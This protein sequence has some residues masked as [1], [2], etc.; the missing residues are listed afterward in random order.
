MRPV[1]LIE[2]DTLYWVL[3]VFDT[4]RNLIDADSLP[5]FVVRKNGAATADTVTVVKRAATTGLYDCSL[6]P[7][8]YVEG[9]HFTVQETLVLST[10]SYVNTWNFMVVA[11]ESVEDSSSEV[12]TGSERLSVIVKDSDLNLLSG[13]EV[14]IEGLGVSATTEQP[15][16]QILFMLNPA[17]YSF[18]VTTA[19]GYDPVD[20]IVYEVLADIEDQEII[21]ILTV[22][23]DVL[24]EVDLSGIKRVKTKEMEIEAFD[25]RILQEA[26]SRAQEPPC[27]CDVDWCK[28]LPKC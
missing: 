16:G 11:E 2:A 8:T 6:L 9:D 5:T 1:Q 27:F 13:I 20:A 7:G 3:P 28:A 21:F 15:T 23:T 14:T 18:I 4:S 17:E 22:D 24:D 12:G 10:I 25:P 19:N 26:Q